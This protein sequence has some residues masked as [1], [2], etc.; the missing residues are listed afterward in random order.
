[1]YDCCANALILYT[2]RAASS[3]AGISRKLG[4]DRVLLLEPARI[5]H[6]TSTNLSHAGSRRSQAPPGPTGALTRDSARN[7][8]VLWAALLNSIMWERV[9]RFLQADAFRMQA[10]LT[11]AAKAVPGPPS[12]QFGHSTFE[13]H[14]A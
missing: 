7:S 12:K 4:T 6:R 2:I 8:D 13:H 5:V 11:A 3:L 14:I 1:M 10:L 9:C